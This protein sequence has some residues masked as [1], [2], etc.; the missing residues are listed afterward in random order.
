MMWYHDVV[1]LCRTKYGTE[2]VILSDIVRPTA[3]MQPEICE[4]RE[5]L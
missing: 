1:S 4:C 3:E 2:N 5:R